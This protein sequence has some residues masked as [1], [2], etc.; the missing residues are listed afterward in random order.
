MKAVGTIKKHKDLILIERTFQKDG[1]VDCEDAPPKDQYGVELREGDTVIRIK[2]ERRKNLKKFD[3]LYR[4][5]TRSDS[6]SERTQAYIKEML[7]EK[8]K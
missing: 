5:E 7:G 4:V 1:L 6:R 2:K 8:S 3:R